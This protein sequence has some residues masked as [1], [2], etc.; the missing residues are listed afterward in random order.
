MPADDDHALAVVGD[1]L[2]TRLVDVTFRAC[3][4]DLASFGGS[5]LQR[6]TF[7]DCVL[8][9]TDFLEAR[10]EKVRFERCDLTRADFREARLRDCVLRGCTIEQLEGV[11]ALRGA[12]M[13]W[14]DIVA[15]AGTWAAAL[16]ID[17]LDD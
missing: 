2:L 1:R 10:L 15:G 17:V 5:G 12:S 13:D 3:R 8:A 9:Q 16:G 4:I 7:E 11:T 14:S 6:V